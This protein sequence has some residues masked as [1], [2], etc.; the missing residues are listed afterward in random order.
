AVGVFVN[1]EPPQVAE[2]LH[3]GVIDIAQLHGGEREEY[4]TTLRKLTDKPI[5]KAFNVTNERDIS[6]ALKSTADYVLLD[7]PL[8]GSGTRFNWELLKN[9]GRP[10]FLAGGLD[11]ENVFGAVQRL[12]PF[13][14]DVSSGIETDGIKD[15]DKMKRFAAVREL[16][17]T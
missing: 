2:L 15:F 6:L 7:S 14:V 10:Y 8:A 13:A 12:K 5:I 9:F 3:C 16:K 1:E 11:P 17:G 4:I